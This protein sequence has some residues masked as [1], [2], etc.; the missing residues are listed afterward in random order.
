MTPMSLP[1]EKRQQVPAAGF[2]NFVLMTLGTGI[3]GGIIHKG[4]LLDVSAEIGHM[5]INA[6]AGEMS[7]RQYRLS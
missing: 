2:D 4:K 3:G 7:V 5:S 1:W 6:D